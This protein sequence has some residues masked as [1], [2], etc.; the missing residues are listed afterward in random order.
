MFENWVDLK[1]IFRVF[2]SICLMCSGV[3]IYAQTSPS[4]I[5]TLE[6][7]D[8]SLSLGLSQS[9]NFMS[10]LTTQAMNHN[11]KL[12]VKFS[13]ADFVRRGNLSLN[14]KHN[15]PSN[16]KSVSDTFGLD[17]N[18]PIEF[19]EAFNTRIRLSGS[20]AF[21]PAEIT[22]NSVKT[23]LNIE[24]NFRL[25]A[26]Q[27][28]LT[29]KFD[30]TIFPDLLPQTNSFSLRD[31]FTSNINFNLQGRASGVN[32]S[33][34]I[35][36][37]ATL[38]A[39][40]PN[41][42]KS[43]FKFQS[44]VSGGSGFLTLD[45]RFNSGLDTFQSGGDP[46]GD[47]DPR[48]RQN[49]EGCPGSCLVDDDGDGL[50]DEDGA[51]REQHLNAPIYDIQNPAF[52]PAFIF[53]DD[54]DGKIDETADASRFTAVLGSKLKFDTFNTSATVSHSG[55]FNSEN[56]SNGNRQTKLQL[57]SSFKFDSLSL[58]AKTD[59]ISTRFS[60]NSSKDS[61]RINLGVSSRLKIFDIQIS[62]N[63]NETFTRLLNNSIADQNSSKRALNIRFPIAKNLDLNIKALGYQRTTFP[64]DP[65]KPDQV[66][67]QTGLAM[68]VK[69]DFGSVTLNV[70][71]SEFPL[72]PDKNR[73]TMSANASLKQNFIE[74][75]RF[76]TNSSFSF[77]SSGVSTRLGVAISIR[78]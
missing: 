71:Q 4:Q 22:K 54:E 20:A 56:R 78:F 68:N 21:F 32:T 23:N 29:G 44:A 65:G 43:T 9:R 48:D 66:S 53:D 64:N 39:L 14:N 74:N 10:M 28:R 69:F 61:N 27:G 31:T 52:N 35:A 46:I 24:N 2:L 7:V 55:N 58:T 60:G 67:N 33:M 8:L 47:R 26:V 6:G 30:A 50:I 37:G 70:N 15:R 17:I 5:L 19:S 62:S 1:R 51:G 57:N 72:E 34:Q 36:Q 45:A 41:K 38:V 76:Q 75:V 12:G 3:L 49:G 42:T 73:V 40:D 18:L 13:I 63:L 25:D 16:P 11:T 77:S 59:Q